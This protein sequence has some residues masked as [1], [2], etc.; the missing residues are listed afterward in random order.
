MGGI[1]GQKC[2]TA[3]GGRAPFWGAY[4]KKYFKKTLFDLL[5]HRFSLPLHSQSK[6]CR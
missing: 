6:G 1:G 3:V 4:L 5:Y 2:T